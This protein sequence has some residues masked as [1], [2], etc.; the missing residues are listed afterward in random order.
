MPCPGPKNNAWLVFFYV[1]I[2]AMDARQ[3]KGLVLAKNKGI[4]QVAGG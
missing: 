2:I 1:H 3:E 4:R